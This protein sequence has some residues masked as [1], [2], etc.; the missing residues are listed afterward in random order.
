MMAFLRAV[1]RWFG[2]LL[3]LPML[4]QAVTGIFMVAA[5]PFGELARPA[6]PASPG[7]PHPMAAVVAVAEAAAP[8]SVLLRYEASDDARHPAVVDLG[9]PGQRAADTRI[10]VDPASLAVLGQA[11]H[12]DSLY[13]WVH[14]VHETLLIPG[15]AGRN[16]I[17]CCGIGLTILALTGVPIFWP[18]HGRW[19][20]ALTVPFG[21]T[22]YRLQRGLHSAIGGWVM[23]LLFLQAAS[24]VTMAFPQ[25]FGAFFGVPQLRMAPGQAPGGNGPRTVVLAGVEAALRDAAPDMRLVSLRFPPGA[26]R[27][28]MAVMRPEGSDDGPPTLV[29]LDPATHRVLGKRDP[30]AGPTGAKVLAWLRTLHE[31]A[32]LGPVWRLAVGLTGLAL[33]VFPITGVAMWL[34][35]RSA[36]RKRQMHATLQGAGE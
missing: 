20:A 34:L 12:P 14:A 22:G 30:D 33:V 17:G 5:P 25:A 36:R 9:R 35:R 3:A 29:M 15:P 16:V 31:G 28:L 21:A 6:P 26:G 19:R 2:L 18:R 1:H 23:V 4:I 10:Y 8:G 11:A 13:R 7:L 27:P 24:G 32:G